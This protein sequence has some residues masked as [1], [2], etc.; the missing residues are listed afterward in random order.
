[1]SSSGRTPSLDVEGVLLEGAERL[2][3]RVGIGALSVRRM[4]A[5]AGVAPMGVYSRFGG[6]HGVLDALLAQGFDE[7]DA[8][9]AAVND[10]DPL[11]ALAD[12]ARRYR[13]FAKTHPALYGLMFDRGIPGWQPSP[14]ALAHSAASFGR[15]TGH[16]SNAMTA[17]ALAASDPAE[18]AQ[19]LWSASHGVVSLELR[20]IGFVDDIDAHH[21]LVVQT[22]LTGLSSAGQRRSRSGWAPRPA[23]GQKSSIAQ[24]KSAKGA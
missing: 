10:P 21:E 6:K 24:T 11:G 4:A 8:A 23:P 9:L 7:L 12:A 16:V 2:L 18:V 22:M 14:A 13:A 3:E 17:G 5:E 15:L 19:R 1:M 20:G